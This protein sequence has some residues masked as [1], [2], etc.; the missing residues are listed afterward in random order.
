M[1]VD[2]VWKEPEFEKRSRVWE[3]CRQFLL[4]VVMALSKLILGNVH[5]SLHAPFFS[6][7]K[8]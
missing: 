2:D 6:C 1:T 3:I 7:F 8:S 5:K 4:F